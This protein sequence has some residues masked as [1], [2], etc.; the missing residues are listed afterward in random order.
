MSRFAETCRYSPNKAADGASGSA[1]AGGPERDMVAA[2]A[3]AAAQLEA[4]TA[5]AV[6]AKGGVETAELESS[7]RCACTASALRVPCD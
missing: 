4:A 7:I 2:A 3:R 5:A 1:A 6:E